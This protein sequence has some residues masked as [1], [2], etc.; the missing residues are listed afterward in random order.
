MCVQI[1]NTATCFMILVFHVVLWGFFLDYLCWSLSLFSLSPS[2]CSSA[3]TAP[4]SWRWNRK[5]DFKHL[6]KGGLTF[7]QH[8]VWCCDMKFA[9]R[10]PGQRTLCCKKK[11]LGGHWS[12]W[13][14][15]AKVKGL[16]ERNKPFNPTPGPL[17]C[18][19]CSIHRNRIESWALRAERRL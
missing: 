3:L 12:P 7:D 5:F 17:S 18:I 2:F 6:Q 10:E 1:S 8:A 9:S 4:D 15:G 14:R 16:L 19:W 11:G 13:Q